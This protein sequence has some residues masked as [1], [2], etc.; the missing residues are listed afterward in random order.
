MGRK[1]APSRLEQRSQAAART[2]ARDWATL[3]WNKDR[4]KIG[5][6]PIWGW[7]MIVVAILGLLLYFGSPPRMWTGIA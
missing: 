1:R 5:P 3:T 2:A 4:R 6:L 7:N